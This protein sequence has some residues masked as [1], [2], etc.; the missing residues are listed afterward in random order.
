MFV[1]WSKKRDAILKGEK[2]MKLENVD[3]LEEHRTALAKCD[4]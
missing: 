3:G 4:R 1:L 2:A